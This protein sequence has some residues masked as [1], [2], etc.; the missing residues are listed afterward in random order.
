VNVVVSDG[1][2]TD[3]EEIQIT[4][5]EVNV[6]PV[7]TGIGNKSVAWNN[8][9][10]FTATATDA[11]L[12]ANT[13]TYSLVGTIPPGASITS[14]GVFTWTPTSA[15]IGSFTFKVKVTDNGS[16]NLYDDEEITITVGK[17]PTY[18]TTTVSGSVQYSDPAPFTSKLYDVGNDPN[19]S[20]AAANISLWIP[21]SSMTVGYTITG[22]TLTGNAVT[23]GSGMATPNT[24][25]INL[26]P[27]ITPATYQVNS[28]FAG[29]ALYGLSQDVDNLTVTKEDAILDYIGNELVATISSTNLTANIDLR[30]AVQDIDDGTRGDIRNAQVKLVFDGATVLDWTNLSTLVDPYTGVISKA[31]TKTLSGTSTAEIYDLQV[32]IRNYYTADVLTVPITVYVATGDFITG[33]GHIIPSASAGVLPSAPNSRTNFGFNVKYNKKGTSLQG[34]LNFVWRSGGRVYQA[35]STATDALGVDISN[36]NAKTASF[37]SKCNVV[38]ITDPNNPI[39][40]GPNLGGNRVMQVTMTDRGEP[41]NND[42]IGFALWNGNTLVYS[43]QWTGTNTTN[44]LLAGGNLVVHSGFNVGGSGVIASSGNPRVVEN[45][46]APVIQSSLLNVQAYPNPAQ[47]QF[48]IKLESSNTKDAISIIVY[49]MN[50][51]VIETKQNLKAGQSLVLGGM[52]RPG[53]YV[54]EMIQGGQHKQLK[55]VK[56]PD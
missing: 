27:N 46:S 39:T 43:S 26:A 42:D 28:S 1:T 52:Y 19:Y 24:M 12:P 6:A 34:K 23:N 49:G 32:Y 41:G 21:L 15:Q 3:E 44:K 29:T 4:V 5:A 13:L 53:I 56:I 50:G 11:D 37:T 47:S 18:I 55:L 10:S 17:R 14:A 54:L 35:K 48:N 9:L 2:T 25:M 16:P 36:D 33:G 30:V 38:D 22:Q 51:K 45:I 8:L 31:V 7:L 40:I 20:N